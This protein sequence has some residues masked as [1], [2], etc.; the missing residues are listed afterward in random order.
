MNPAVLAAKT[1]C[2]HIPPTGRFVEVD[3]LSIVLWIVLQRRVA[4]QAARAAPTTCNAIRSSLGEAAVLEGAC[5]DARRACEPSLGV[6][7]ATL[8]L[9]A[10]PCMRKG[11][12]GNADGMETRDLPVTRRKH[13]ERSPMTHNQWE[14]K[15]KIKDIGL[16]DATE[17]QNSAPE[18]GTLLTVHGENVELLQGAIGLVARGRHPC[19]SR[20]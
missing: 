2:A 5:S 13:A 17:T 16:D 14:M 8:L 10:A 9:I 4:P 1:Q 15:M 6:S 7:A 20:A 12:E 3:V 19:T 11:S 18:R